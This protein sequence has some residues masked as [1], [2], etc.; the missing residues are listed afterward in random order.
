MAVY[1]TGAIEIW[2]KTEDERESRKETKLQKSACE[3]V[4]T[5]SS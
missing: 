5:I 3:Q 4:G 1:N 2:L